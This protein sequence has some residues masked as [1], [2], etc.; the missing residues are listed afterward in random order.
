[1]TVE[2]SSDARVDVETARGKL[3]F[4]LSEQPP[5]LRCAYLRGA[6]IVERSPNLNFSYPARIA[7]FEANCAR[8]GCWVAAGWG[9]GLADSEDKPHLEGMKS[10]STQLA[11]C[12]CGHVSRAD[13]SSCRGP[14]SRTHRSRR[15]LPRGRCRPPL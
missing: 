4:R 12:E 2:S 6:V 7:G 11:A 5:G 10:D 14:C 3:S 9:G 15:P 13:P 8:I 1:M